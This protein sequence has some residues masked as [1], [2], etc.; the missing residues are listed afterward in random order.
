VSGDLAGRLAEYAW[1][2]GFGD[3][4]AEV[5]H[6]AK[7]RVIDSLGCALGAYA[8]EP[9]KV[10]RAVVHELGGVPAAT[11]LGSRDRSSPPL[12]AFV[13]GIMVRYLDYNDTYL[14]REPA[15]PSDNIPAA[16]AVAESEGRSGAD[17][18]TAIVLAYE[19]QCRLA[20]AASLRARGWDHVTYGAFSVAASAAKLMGLDPDRI[21]HALGL[22]GVAGV[23]LRQTRAGELSMWKGAAFANTARNAVLAA[24]LARAGM[25]GPAPIFEG[26]FGFFRQVSGEFDPG[27]LGGQG[28]PFRITDTSIKVWP[29]EYHAQPG[30]EAALRVRERGVAVDDIDEVVIHTFRAAVEIIA[31]DPEKWRPRTRE[32]ADHSLPYCVAVALADGTVTPA[33]FLP[34]RLAD[35]R[36]HALLDRTRVV[37]DPGLTERYPEAVPT[38]LEVR[39]RSGETVVERVDYPRGHARNPVSDAEVEQKFLS[40]TGGLLSPAQQDAALARLWR[41]EEEEDLRAL[42]GTV[43]V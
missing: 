16:L 23:A 36:I 5:V 8:A 21:R 38:V 32:T 10:A 30:I 28:V 39:L 12:A 33:Q 4:P 34:H 11:I 29:A 26:E 41:L 27:P 9:V 37:E 43:V 22:S 14:S 6:E 15:H 19:I 35:E 20:D 31:K 17:L 25:T 40:L 18:I 1:G 42:L 2:L 13:N 24:S 3:L 7:R